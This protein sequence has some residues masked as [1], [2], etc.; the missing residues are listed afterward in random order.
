MAEK[1]ANRSPP[2]G[3]SGK[4]LKRVEGRHQD[5]ARNRPMLR[6]I[7]GDTRAN[8]EP[9]H[10][11]GLARPRLSQIVE[12]Y[13]RVREQ[14]LRAGAAAARRVAPV[15]EHNDISV[16]KKVVQDE[17]HRPGAGVPAKAHQGRRVVS[18]S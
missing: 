17:G 9:Y 11:Y 16:W 15:V 8:T 13:E 18:A 1:L 4:G 12:D 5:Q 10:N 14:R 7:C 6:E 2:V 3:I